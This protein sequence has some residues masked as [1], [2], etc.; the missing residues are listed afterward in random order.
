MKDLVNAF[1]AD[2]IQAASN[3]SFI[4]Y[5]WFVKY[6]LEIV[7]QIALELC[8]KYPNAD[9]DIV[10]L[11]VWFHDYGKIVDY[12]NQYKATLTLGKKKLLKLGFS[13]IVVEEVISYMEQFDKKENLD[14]APIELQIVSS[15]DGASHFIGPFYH[16][17]WK[18]FHTW[19]DDAL[20][21]ENRR[22]SRVDWEMKIVL[23]EVKKA[24]K[25]RF[26]YFKETNGQLP[27]RYL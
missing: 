12:D 21:E 17:F 20:L 22:K 10:L 13:K 5:T 19:T 4:H 25:D 16:I 26:I 7:E 1:K 24:F 27:E 6:H 9:V 15:A 2:V 18:E 23:P 3:T 14:K 8:E 11:L